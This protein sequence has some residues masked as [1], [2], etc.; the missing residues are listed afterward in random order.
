[1]GAMIR[2]K[3][4]SLTPL[5]PT[6]G[7]PQSLRAA[8]SLC[9][10]SNFP[11]NLIWGQQNSQI[12]NDA[13]RFLCG[14]AHPHAGGQEGYPRPP[15]M[16]VLAVSPRLAFE[17]ILV[18]LWQDADGAIVLTVSDD[19]VGQRDGLTASPGAGPGDIISKGLVNQ[20]GGMMPVRDY[21]GTTTKL[22]TTMR[23]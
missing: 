11:I 14:A 22:W 13:D 2:P 17:T 12:Y 6:S 20:I 18:A 21:K 3:H 15:A 5:G 7:R 16:V 23:I 10:A 19:G 1:M 8:V 9:R 4:R